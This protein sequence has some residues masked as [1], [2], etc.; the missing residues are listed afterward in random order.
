ML[1]VAML[2]NVL[3]DLLELP[4]NIGTRV[5]AEKVFYEISF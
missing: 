4:G 2:L 1:S 3:L 5:A